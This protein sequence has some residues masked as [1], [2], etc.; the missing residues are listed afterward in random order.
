MKSIVVLQQVPHETPGT[1]A[2][3]L[4]DAGLS[5]RSIE[6]FRQTPEDLQLES[7]AGLIVLGGPMN[8][9][10]IDRYPF[11]KLELEWIRKALDNDLPTLG[12]CLGSQ[13]LAKALGAAVYPNE[14]KEIGWHEIEL[15]PE[16]ASDHLFAGCERRQTVFQWHGDTFGLPAG[17]VHLA[18]S[19]LC[20]S[21]AFRCGSNAYGLQFHIEVTAKMVEQW[22]DEPS[23]RQELASL[24]Y[25]GLNSIRNRT[26]KALSQMHALGTRVL[27]RFAAICREN[28]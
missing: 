2:T 27:P 16:A 18:R 22:L 11:L 8:V 19:E 14:V 20:H 25:I 23:N 15:T 1:L 4:A 5:V 12:I 17:A 24:D 3:V 26:P 9:D 13:L 6:L 7:A 21:Q 10:Q 28:A